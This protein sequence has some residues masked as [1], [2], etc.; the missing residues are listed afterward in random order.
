M[1]VYT[2]RQKKLFDW[3]AQENIAMAIFEDTEGRRDPAIRW[4]T[5]QPGDAL[6][7]LTADSHTML[8]PWDI[9]IALRMADAEM[10][11]AYTDFE[12][13]ALQAIRSAAEYFN[14]AF[15]DRVEV[16][17]ATPYP[18]FLSYVEMLDDYDVICRNEGI[19]TE[20][21]R[22]RAVK[23]AEEIAIYRN[24]SVITNELIDL[25]ETGVRNGKLVTEADMALFIEHACR[26]RGCEGTG[27]ETLVA[28]PTR[29]FGIHAFPAY[30]TAPF[31]TAG[32]SILDFGVTYQGYTSDVTLTFARPPLSR[33]QERLLTLTEKA[34]RLALNMVEDGVPTRSIALAVDGFFANAKK[35]MPHG[36]GH[37]IGLEAHEA[38][39]LNSRASNGW[40]LKP[41]M[42]FTL[43]P[44]L[45]EN[46]HGG[47]RLENDILL[48]ESGVEVLTTSRIIRL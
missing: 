36:L 6:L 30:T 28:G 10:I 20:V 17:P 13:Q 39:A 46:A 31:A 41:G 43:E 26:V 45:Y 18:L 47:C 38:P 37:G 19:H 7:L 12:R 48:T 32:L 24:V 4:L 22:F 25:L 27:F 29:S 23:D 21:A 3:M 8:I 14:V 40:V 11:V 1:S 16:S 33:P 34:Y 15:G 9:H 2:E 42:I 44:G 5:G 35:S